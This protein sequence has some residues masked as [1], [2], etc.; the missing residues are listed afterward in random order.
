MALLS[1]TEMEKVREAIAEVERLTDAEL[2]TVLAR[3]SDDYHYIPT[4][5]AAI[6]AIVSPSVIALTPFWL[7]VWEVVLGQLIVF[8]VLAVLLRV[9]SVMFRLIPKHVSHWR[10][11]NMARRQ[12]LENNLHYTAGETGVLIFVSETEHYAEIIADRGISRHV[13]NDEWQA[14][15]HNLTQQVK[16]GKTLDGFLECISSCGEILQRVAPV[17]AQ[18]NELPNHLIVLD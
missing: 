18:K 1:D 8:V 17:T 16:A 11:A 5:W 9:P 3:Q 4:L 7:E 10:A 14:V 6:I 15:I 12:F 2:V 13:G